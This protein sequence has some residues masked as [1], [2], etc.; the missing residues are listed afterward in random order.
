MSD[1]IPIVLAADCPPCLDCKEPWCVKH[2]EHYGLCDCVGP[3]NAEELG[4]DVVEEGGKL[5]GIKS[6]TG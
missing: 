1:K 2:Q 6:R 5:W 4:Y 3:A